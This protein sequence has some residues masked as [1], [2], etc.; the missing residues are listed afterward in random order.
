MQGWFFEKW[1]SHAHVR[2]PCLCAHSEHCQNE[3]AALELVHVNFFLSITLFLE[4]FVNLVKYIHP[5]LY[6]NQVT[7]LLCLTFSELS[8]S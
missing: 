3:R 4:P 8:S 6:N 1:A 5:D 7:N 2:L